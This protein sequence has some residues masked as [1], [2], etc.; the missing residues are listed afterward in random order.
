MARNP[1]RRQ[2][3]A[4]A[5]LEVIGA[6]GGRGLTHRAVDA[7]AEVPA[8]TTAN[9]FPTRASLFSGMAQR[10]FTRIAPAQQSLERLRRLPA[11]ADAFAAYTR[12][13]VE[14]LLAVPQLAL[15]LI[16]LRLEAARS[17]ELAAELGDFLR[18][19]FS[20]DDKFH[21]T[22]GLPGGADEILLLH[23]AVDGIVLDRLTTPIEPGRDPLR[24]A[25][26]LTRRILGRG[27]AVQQ[28][29]AS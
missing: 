8:G 4:D 13:V 7:W 12:Y 15:A 21:A 20:E 29:I 19:G 10:I 6:E 14:R 27:T 26:D 25:E 28:E 16:E 22:R 23:Y 3:I 2:R 17:P 24:D 5:A 18:R 1:E 9:Y 11:D